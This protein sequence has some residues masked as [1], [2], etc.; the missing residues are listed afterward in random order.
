MAP[1]IVKL[2]KGNKREHN[3]GPISPITKEESKDLEGAYRKRARFD[4]FAQDVVKRIKKVGRPTIG[5]K[6]K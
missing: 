2:L 1:R 4:P 3:R 5:K 6:E